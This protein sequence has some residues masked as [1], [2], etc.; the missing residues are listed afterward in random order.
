MTLR[1]SGKKA[2]GMLPDQILPSDATT[3]EPPAPRSNGQFRAGWPQ[4][5]ASGRNH[6]D[7]WQVRRSSGGLVVIL[8]TGQNHDPLDISLE[9]SGQPSLDVERSAAKQLP[10]ANSAPL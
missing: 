6:Q 8:A 3:G 10:P 2:R 9:A 7:R 1:D 4:G 5:I